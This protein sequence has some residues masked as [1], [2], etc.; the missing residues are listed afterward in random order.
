MLSSSTNS[1]PVDP[2]ASTSHNVV[3]K[4]KDKAGWGEDSWGAARSIGKGKGGK[5]FG[6]GG[7]GGSGMR[8]GK[9]LKAGAYGEAAGRTFAVLEVRCS[10]WRVVSC[11]VSQSLDTCVHIFTNSDP[12]HE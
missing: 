12:R 5:D 7:R 11:F 6:G 1:G 10:S 3:L 9:P 4:K 2:F 8:H